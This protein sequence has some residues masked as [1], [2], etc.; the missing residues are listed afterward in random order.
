MSK[1]TFHADVHSQ[2]YASLYFIERTSLTY[3][4]SSNRMRDPELSH[5]LEK[6]GIEW[7]W[8]I[9]SHDFIIAL[10]SNPSMQEVNI[11]LDKFAADRIRA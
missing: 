5:G 10:F 4:Q 2:S 7:T 3:L 11:F 8:K 1:E 6:L 9:Q